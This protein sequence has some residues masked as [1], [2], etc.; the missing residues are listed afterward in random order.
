MISIYVDFHNINPEGAVR[1]NTIGTIKDLNRQGVVLK[2]GLVVRLYCEELEVTGTVEFAESEHLWAARFN[3]KE[4][5][6][7]KTE[8]AGN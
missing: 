1:L 3:P 5:K 7:L 8:D 6:S 2:N 4:I